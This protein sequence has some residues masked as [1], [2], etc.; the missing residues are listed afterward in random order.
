MNETAD[1]AKLKVVSIHLEGETLQWHQGYANVQTAEGRTL[2]RTKYVAA[3]KGRFIDQPFDDPM[4]E[5]KNL[6]QEGSFSYYQHES[7]GLLHK[8]SLVEKVSEH[9]TIN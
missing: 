2:S 5:M 6:R 9:A 7:D 3:L 1:D 4:L 8:V